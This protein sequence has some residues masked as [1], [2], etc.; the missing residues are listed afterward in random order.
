MS[1]YA[2]ILV[3]LPVLFF[4]PLRT[5]LFDFRARGREEEKEREKHELVPSHMCLDPGLN[6]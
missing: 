5:C 1:T 6:L 3:L 4:N 2:A